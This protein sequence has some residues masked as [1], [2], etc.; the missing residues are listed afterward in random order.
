MDFFI[1]SDSNSHLDNICN[2]MIILTMKNPKLINKLIINKE[3]KG[4]EFYDGQ[5]K[6]RQTANQRVF[7]LGISN[8]DI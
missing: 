3:Y 7:S 1:S 8:G 6:E 5:F 2:G 4:V